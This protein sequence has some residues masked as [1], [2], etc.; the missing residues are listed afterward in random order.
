MAF[1]LRTMPGSRSMDSGL[2][3]EVYKE[4]QGD[5]FDSSGLYL[6]WESLPLEILNEEEEEKWVQIIFG[7]GKG[8]K[9]CLNIL[10]ILHFFIISFVGFFLYFSV[11][12]KEFYWEDIK[13]YIRDCQP[14]AILNW[15]SCVY[16]LW[17]QISHTK[18]FFHLGHFLH[19]AIP[20]KK[21][22]ETL[23][24][25]GKGKCQKSFVYLTVCSKP[26]LVLSKH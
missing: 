10:K 12:S 6:S 21:Q 4:A 17:K 15:R 2:N 11:S 9:Q 5:E 22:P 26:T 25:A 1:A 18:L 13:G 23:P 8:K 24:R 7:K 3:Y 14:V 19:G 20:E 16:F